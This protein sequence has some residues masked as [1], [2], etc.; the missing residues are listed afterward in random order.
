MPGLGRELRPAKASPDYSVTAALRVQAADWPTGRSPEAWSAPQ[1]SPGPAAILGGNRELAL[2]LGRPR[3]RPC[4][5]LWVRCMG[6]G[7]Q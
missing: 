2:E 7:G 6:W 1:P 3:L 4:S 5:D